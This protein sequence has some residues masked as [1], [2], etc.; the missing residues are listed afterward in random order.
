VNFYYGGKRPVDAFQIPLDTVS[1]LN[2]IPSK[3]RYVGMTVKVLSG[4]TLDANGKNVPDEYWLVGGTKNSNWTRKPSVLDGKLSLSANT[5]NSSIELLYDG[6]PIGV[7]ADLTDILTAWQTD[8]YITAGGIMTDSGTKYLVLFYN[9]NTIPPVRIDL[10]GIGGGGEGS[11]AT[12]DYA[13]TGYVHYAII[14]SLRQYA[15]SADTVDAISQAFKPSIS[16]NTYS[17]AQQLA[18]SGNIGT[19]IDVKNDDYTS[20]A[21]T[22]YSGLYIVTGDGEVSKLAFE[23]PNQD[24]SG[25]IENLKGRVGTL[26]SNVS[27]I[28]DYLYW[29]TDDELVIE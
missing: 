5:S 20:S 6:E 11:G 7:A 22:Y 12:G 1:D 26:E 4:C 21:A 28:M 9:D 15:T 18:T 24:I 19:I 8:K 23:S 2:G 14:E 10:T 3:Y 25:D 13:T 17:D 16:A 27:N 29:E